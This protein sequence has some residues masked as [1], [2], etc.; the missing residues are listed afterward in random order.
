MGMLMQSVEEGSSKRRRCSWEIFFSVTKWTI[1]SSVV[2]C[3]C[4][5]SRRIFCLHS[6]REK[7]RSFWVLYIVILEGIFIP[8]SENVSSL[9]PQDAYACTEGVLGRPVALVFSPSF[10]RPRR[11]RTS[12]RSKRF[13]TLRF[14]ADLLDFP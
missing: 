4:E 2:I 6:F 9:T 11:R 3:R 7:D 1:S 5:R 10:H 14:F 8:S 12:M 13:K